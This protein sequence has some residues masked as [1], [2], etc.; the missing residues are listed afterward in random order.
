MKNK[1]LIYPLILVGFLLILTN[2]CK[3]DE[4]TS[5]KV[6]VITWGNPV[7][8]HYGTLLSAIQLNATA[9]VIGTFVYTPTTGTKLN[10]GLNQILKVVFTPTDAS[11][12]DTVSKTVKIN[13]IAKKVPIITWPNPTDIAYGTL[14]SSKQLNASADVSGTFVYT[15]SIGTKLSVGLNQALKVVF[16]PIDMISNDTV[17]KTVK[18][19]VNDIVTDIDGNVYNTVTIGAQVWMV[20]NLRTTK[21]NDSTAIPKVTDATAWGALTTPGV[22]TYNNTSNTDTINTYGRLYNWYTVATGKLAPTGWHVPTDAE[23]TTLTTYL[24]G[25]SIAGGKLKELGTTHWQSPNTGADNTTGFTALPG[26]DRS[27]DGTFGAIGRY[28]AWWSSSEDNTDFAWERNMLNNYSNVYRSYY[29][30]SLGFPVRCVR[31]N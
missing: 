4:K 28:G 24:G 13:V 2:S 25:E 11:N 5:K 17:S 26:G 10:A 21:Y 6:P 20:E 7:D 15:P 14:L 29:Y 9:D 23:W 27:N 1:N 19:N 18:I 30:K 12:N 16:T 8:I 22:C 31:D 3:K